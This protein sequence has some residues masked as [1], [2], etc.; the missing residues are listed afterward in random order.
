[1]KKKEANYPMGIT[2]LKLGYM[3]FDSQNHSFQDVKTKT[4]KIQYECFLI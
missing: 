2:L 4:H 1:M 3:K